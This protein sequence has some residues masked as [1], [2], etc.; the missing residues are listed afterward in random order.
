MKYD[1]ID[2]DT[3][4]TIHWDPPYTTGEWAHSPEVEE[5]RQIVYNRTE[6]WDIYDDEH[7][8]LYLKFWFDFLYRLKLI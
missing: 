4:G 2:W 7:K 8:S 6:T 3:H 1:K 5:L